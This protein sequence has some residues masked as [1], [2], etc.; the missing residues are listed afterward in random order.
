[1]SCDYLS[2]RFS[3]GE[4]FAMRLFGRS[5]E[6][7]ARCL[8]SICV[9]CFSSHTYGQRSVTFPLL[10][11]PGEIQA[12]LYG[13]GTRGVIL[14]HGGRFNKESWKK[15]AQA[16]ANAGFLVLALRFRGDV[17][18]PDGSPGSFGSHAD[19]AADV[20]AA[21]SYLHRTGVTTISAVGA[22]LGGDAVGDADAQ[23]KPGD[24]ARIVF[25]GS[26]G[27]S[28]PEK[29]TGRKLFIVA[30]KDSSASG[31]RLPEISKNYQKAPQPKKL[32]ILE[33]SAHA[34]YLFDTDQGPR[35]LNE[36]L[37]FLSEP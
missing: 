24:I 15:Q 4:E 25:L 16:F 8:L 22:S 19:N 29:L 3:S 31:L 33:G 5:R 12:D 32:V 2:S 1:M 10:R 13:S 35:L 20:L 26:S 28:A 7:I 21:V 14:A 6:V 17:S 34:Q 27:G 30:R 18:N 9:A 11:H 23:S 37:R 36:I